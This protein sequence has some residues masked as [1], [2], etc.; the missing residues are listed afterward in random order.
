[1]NIDSKG[2][3]V[4]ASDKDWS[5]EDIVFMYLSVRGAYENK[6]RMLAKKVKQA[7]ALQQLL[8]ALADDESN[9]NT[10]R[11]IQQKMAEMEEKV[12]EE[13]PED[14]YIIGIF[15]KLKPKFLMIKDADIEL[16]NKVVKDC[17]VEEN[18]II[19]VLLEE[20]E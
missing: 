15:T 13:V 14:K 12:N 19:Q 11:E 1:M 7:K 16:V 2:N 5:N 4:E 8:T 10:V 20:T 18:E 6:K 3:I 17:F 9:K